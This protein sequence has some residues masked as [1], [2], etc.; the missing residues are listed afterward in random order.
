MRL[1]D[2]AACAVSLLLLCVLA[3]VAIDLGLAT[4][5]TLQSLLVIGLPMA[6]GWRAGTL[7]VVLYLVAGAAGLPVFAGGRSGTEVFLGPSGG[8]LAGF[9]VVAALAGAWAAR[10][11]RDYLGRLRVFLVSHV[12]LL[13]I[14]TIGLLGAGLTVPQIGEIMLRLLPGLAIKS[15]VGAGLVRLWERFG[16]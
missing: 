5:V 8:F 14:G 16:R 7:A 9:V 3:P 4:P 1:R 2:A 11:R 12:V 10:A 13:A 6:V 15:A